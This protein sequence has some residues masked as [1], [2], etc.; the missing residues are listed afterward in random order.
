MQSRRWCPSIKDGV[1]SYVADKGTYGKEPER[2]YLML[3]IGTVPTQGPNPAHN[4]QYIA[5]GV[6]VHRGG[7]DRTYSQ[8]CLTVSPINYSDC[9]SNFSRGTHGS[10]SVF[11]GD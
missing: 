6:W 3:R 9:I 8:G 1:Y 10:V 4:G 11:S 5:T 2:R 7:Q